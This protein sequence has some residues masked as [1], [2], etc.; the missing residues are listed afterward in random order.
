MNRSLALALLIPTVLTAQQGTITYTYSQKYEF[1]VPEGWERLKDMMPEAGTSTMVLHFKPS[2]SLMTPVAEEAEVG[3][4]RRDRFRG[5]LLWMKRRSNSRG[6]QEVVRDTYVSFE[7]SRV[8]ETREFMGRTFRL[9]EPRPA[10]AWRLTGEQAEHLGHLVI[11]ATAELDGASIEAWFAPAIPVPGGP[12]SYGG[13]PGMILVLLVG[14]GITQYFATGIAL[15]EVD[16]AL[17]RAPE[18][19]DEITR[20][21]YEEI[22]QE[23]LEEIEALNRRRGNRGIGAVG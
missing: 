12:A 23:K 8:V 4:S 9:A 13:L 2:A 11:K 20:D 15:E 6:D 19:G 7:D 14:D 21:E 5:R 16:G 1:E 18:D 3:A 22:V 17:I 10:L